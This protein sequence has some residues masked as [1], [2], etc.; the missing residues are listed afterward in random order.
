MSEDPI[1]TMLTD[2]QIV[3]DVVI[4][5]LFR[6][7]YIGL[8]SPVR[9]LSIAYTDR[10]IDDLFQL[11]YSITEID[12]RWSAE[13]EMVEFLFDHRYDLCFLLWQASAVDDMGELD[14]E[15]QSCDDGDG[16]G[17]TDLH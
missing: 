5:H 3:A 17:A 16:R 7:I 9:P 15:G 4:E 1:S 2:G 8:Y 11:A 10:G 14:A 13:E 6:C 12:G